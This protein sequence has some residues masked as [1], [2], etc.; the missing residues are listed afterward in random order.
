[1]REKMTVSQ[2][3]TDRLIKKMQDEKKLIWDCPFLRHS[4]NWFSKTE[5]KGVNRLLLGG[6]E[7]ITY[8]QLQKHNELSKGSF[9]IPKG[10][11]ANIVCFYG[12][13]HKNISHVEYNSMKA[14]NHPSL[15]YVSI[16]DS[17]KI[18]LQTY[19]LR[20]YEVYNI[21]KIFDRDGKT[22]VPRIGNSIF[23]TY[24]SAEDIVSGYA[25]ASGLNIVESGEGSCYYVGSRDT[26]H[27]TNRSN[28]ISSEAFYRTLFHELIHST[29]VKH[30]LNRDSFRGYNERSGRSREEL[31]AEVGSLLLASEAGFRGD[32]VLA[33]NSDAYILSWIKWMKDNS[34]EVVSGMWGAEKAKTYIL[35]GVASGVDEDCVKDV[36]II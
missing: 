10:T 18:L 20:Y 28:F 6:G 21:N 17:G 23:E 29:G 13:T 7:Y 8:N 5:Y 15:P 3:I 27:M 4:I 16:T 34:N 9:T 12:K 14:K 32:N 35:S 31:I 30:R 19:I 2:I 25:K 36:G 22:L 26:V 24:S 33:D 11:S 1:V